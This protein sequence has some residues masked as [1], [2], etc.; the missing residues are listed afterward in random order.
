MSNPR[1]F[2]HFRFHFRYFPSRP[3]SLFARF[4]LDFFDRSFLSAEDGLPFSL[5]TEPPM[6]DCSRYGSLSFDGQTNNKSGY[7]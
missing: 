3:G 5:K 7:D 2:R 6:I 4:S 1:D